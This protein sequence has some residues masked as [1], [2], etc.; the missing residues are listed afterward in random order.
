MMTLAQAH[1]MLPGSQLIG[2]GALEVQRVHSDKIGR[3]HV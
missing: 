1:A 2:D 3:A